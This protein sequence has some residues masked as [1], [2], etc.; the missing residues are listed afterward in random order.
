M[1]GGLLFR[2]D[3]WSSLFPVG[4]QRR[5]DRVDEA[6]LDR[7]ADAGCGGIFFGVET[8]SQRMQSAV[9]KNLRLDR[10]MPVMRTCVDHGMAPTA[11]S[12][13][14]FPMRPSTMRSIRSP[15]PWTSCSFP[16]GR[17][18]RCVCAV[19]EAPSIRRERTIAVRWAQLD[20]SM[21]LLDEAEIANVRRYPD[22][23]P[24]FYYIP[25]PHLDRDLAKRSLQSSTPVPPCS[26]R[27]IG[28]RRSAGRADRLDGVAAPASR[29]GATWAGPSINSASTCVG[30][31]KSRC[32]RCSRRRL[33]T[34]RIWFPISRCHGLKRGLIRER[35][36]FHQYEY[37]VRTLTQSVRTTDAVLDPPPDAF[38]LLFVNLAEVHEHGYVFL[39]VNV[40]RHGDPLVRPGDALEIRDP[41]MQARTRPNVIR[42]N[43]QRRA[44]TTKH[45]LTQRH[46]PGSG[47]ITIAGATAGRSHVG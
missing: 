27:A 15:W 31:S 30:T 47:T 8:G 44:F 35:T 18:P 24:N 45:H 10:V 39:E 40:P 21:F 11:R 26:S 19:A 12:S 37:D 29:P 33:R 42:N 38:D 7:M 3:G 2:A 32:S 5:V 28:G 4:L 20:I 22:I 43:S 25:T 34:C 23:F 41:V 1:G 6:L 14:G 9:R 46:L 17:R 16:R 36:V 13:P